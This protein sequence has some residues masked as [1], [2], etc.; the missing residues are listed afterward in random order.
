MRKGLLNRIA[1]LLFGA[2]I[3]G[4]QNGHPSQV[5]SKEEFER[6]MREQQLRRK[7]IEAEVRPWLEA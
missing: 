5:V 1:D 3:I 7:Q 4:E 6:K 2:P